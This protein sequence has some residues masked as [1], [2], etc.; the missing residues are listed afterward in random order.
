[1]VEARPE[2]EHEAQDLIEKII[3]GSLTLSDMVYAAPNDSLPA[4]DQSM[5]TRRLSLSETLHSLTDSPAVAKNAKRRRLQSEMLLDGEREN[6]E[7]ITANE[8][9][10]G[11]IKRLERENERL[12]I[13]LSQ[14]T[15]QDELEMEVKELKERIDQESDKN[16]RLKKLEREKEALQTRLSNA[17]EEKNREMCDADE[18]KKRVVQQRLQLAQHTSKS[19]ERDGLV[20]DLTL[21]KEELTSQLAGM[22]QTINEL[23]Q[24]PSSNNDS[25]H[26]TSIASEPPSFSKLNSTDTPNLA[27][28]MEME[29]LKADLEEAEMKTKTA[30]SEFQ[31][32]T[33]QM[34][35]KQA[36]L[37]RL[38]GDL[39]LVNAR[40]T[41][42][43]QTA[44]DF[45]SSKAIL[46]E[47][48]T[49]VKA[50][51]SNIKVTN[52][53]LSVQVESLNTDSQAIIDDLKKSKYEL[54][55]TISR[56]DSLT[57]Q[58]EEEEARRIKAENMV[59]DMNEKFEVA[60]NAKV[61]AETA[62]AQAESEKSEHVKDLQTERTKRLDVDK[63]RAEA[64]SS[65][66]LV[67]IDLKKT[68]SA[69]TEEIEQKKEESQRQ[70]IEHNKTTELLR[71]E[72]TKL[73]EKI[74]L[75]H[76]QS[77]HITEQ[78]HLETVTRL[79]FFYVF[80]HHDR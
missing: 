28:E 4:I 45:S 66:H 3:Y 49:R 73:K 32:L 50:D 46:E 62:C 55:A 56:L 61:K 21:Q 37:D 59:I 40:C 80:T 64:E 13:R 65:T 51:T 54:T 27:M 15:E 23:S 31:E 77:K 79:Y 16:A 44:D 9:L 38:N 47:E 41:R 42:L 1:M 36:E 8:H 11:T 14:I 74:D 6:A 22:Q 26:N 63:R 12:T 20:N 18:W 53:A 2:L 39:E 58:F 30:E 19:Q 25:R 76:D 71:A 67:T 48:L 70:V 33:S 75:L 7:L 10:N 78:L 52:A 34:C 57:T 68:I 60:I 72:T 43:Q 35:V 5:S 69:L 24:Y 29:R 17:L